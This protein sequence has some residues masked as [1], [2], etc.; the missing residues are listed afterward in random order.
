VEVSTDL[1]AYVGCIAGAILIDDYKRGLIE[2]GFADAEII[3]T[4][5]DLNIYA[6]LDNQASC[7]TSLPVA[8]ASC[9]GPMSDSLPTDKPALGRLAD[10]LTRYSVNDYAASVKVFAVKPANQ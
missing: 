5:Q 1:L 7:S 6:K 4:K 2:A 3:D 8:S 10:L 9:C